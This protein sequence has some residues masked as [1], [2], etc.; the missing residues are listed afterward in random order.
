MSLFKRRAADPATRIAEF[1]TW[2]S[3]AG[4]AR[5]AAALEARDPAAMTDELTNRI[6][7]I[8]PH[9]AWELAPGSVSEH[10]LVVTSGG[11]PD[12]RV[13]A[14]RWLLSAVPADDTWSYSDL[15]PPVAEPDDVILS[16]EGGP[17]IAFADVRLSARRTGSRF[18]VVLYHPA[19]IE[20]PEEPRRQ[21]AFLAL[22][23]ALGEADVELWIGGIDVATHAPLDG[24]GLSALRAVVADL[25]SENIDEDGQPGWALLE[26]QGPDGPI[27]AATQVPLHPLTAPQLT[28]HVAMAVQYADLTDAGLPGPGSLEP[29]RELEDRLSATLGADGRVVAHES[30]AGLRVVHAYADSDSDAAQRARSTSWGWDQ[31]RVEVMV[32]DD[33]GW[34]SVAHLRA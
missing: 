32:S 8:D 18:D 20:L 17:D 28:V 33:P 1:W 7:A 25:R 26:G 3:S 15:R 29:L 19:F 22:D 21:I 13:L 12:L 2:W 14:R 4:A 6:G 9:L 34:E 30:S 11:D 23:A 24:F 16:S 27:L 5:T 10:T 31:G